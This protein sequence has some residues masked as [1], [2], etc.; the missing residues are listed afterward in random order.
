MEV[1]SQRRS[2][3]IA[4]AIE[5]AEF[6]PVHSHPT[7]QTQVSDKVVNNSNNNGV[8]QKYEGISMYSRP[9]LTGQPNLQTVVET[10]APGGWKAEVER[11]KQTKEFVVATKPDQPLRLAEMPAW[12]RD[13]QEKKKQRMSSSGDSPGVDPPPG[14]GFQDGD[15]EWKTEIKQMLKQKSVTE[16]VIMEMREK[17]EWERL[18]DERR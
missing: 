18:A 1:E 17:P 7:L 9:S 13:L 16:N 8:E 14:S 10:L 4:K 15:A 11:R 3:E 2:L 12:K 5:A 6:K